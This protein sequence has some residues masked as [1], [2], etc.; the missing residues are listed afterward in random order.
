[1]TGIKLDFLLAGNGG[2][3]KV[4]QINVSNQLVGLMMAVMVWLLA[5][6][7]FLYAAS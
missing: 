5:M 2:A 6:S 4:F 3:R 7:L 1:M